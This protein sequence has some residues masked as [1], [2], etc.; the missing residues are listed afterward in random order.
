VTVQLLNEKEK[1]A[2]SGNKPIAWI[3]NT[4]KTRDLNFE[5]VMEYQEIPE[6]YSPEF[7][8]K[9]RWIT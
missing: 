6:Y 7:Y 9:W 4:S 2:H 3:A 8:E 1:P 5:K